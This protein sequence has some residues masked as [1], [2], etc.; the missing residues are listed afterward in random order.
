MS[1]EKL[2][3]EAET[4]HALDWA[5]NLLVRFR[6]LSVLEMTKL[7]PAKFKQIVKQYREVIA[8]RRLL[9]NC[10]ELNQKIDIERRLFWKTRNMKYANRALYYASRRNRNLQAIRKV[11]REKKKEYEQAIRTLRSLWK[12]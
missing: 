2:L 6:P 7:D 5:I 12:K 4:D 1:L 3:A 8:L 10:K 11:Y 9:V